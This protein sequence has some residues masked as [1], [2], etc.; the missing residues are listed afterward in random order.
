MRLGKVEK[1]EG[2]GLNRNQFNNGDEI[3]FQI[4]FYNWDYQ[5]HLNYHSWMKFDHINII[6]NRYMKSGVSMGFNI[7]D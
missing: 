1:K 5:M 7:S 2:K 3:K 4:N 6:A